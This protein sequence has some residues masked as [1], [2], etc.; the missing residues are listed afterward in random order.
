MLALKGATAAFTL[1]CHGKK[2]NAISLQQQT[3]EGQ[4][5]SQELPVHP[6]GA[7]LLQGQPLAQVGQRYWLLGSRL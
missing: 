6:V 3:R 4:Q 1:D 2:K 5:L 7:T